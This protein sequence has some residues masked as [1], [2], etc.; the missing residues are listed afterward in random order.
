MIRIS[1]EHQ[2]FEVSS[3]ERAL[4]D[5]VKQVR[6]LRWIGME[7]EARQAQLALRRRT[8]KDGVLAPHDTD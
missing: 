5:L 1:A 7:K 4:N 8:E 6:K 3:D 2:P